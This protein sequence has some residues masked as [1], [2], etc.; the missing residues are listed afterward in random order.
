MS[1]DHIRCFSFIRHNACMF[2]ISSKD[3]KV[4]VRFYKPFFFFL[5][6]S[7]MQFSGFFLLLKVCLNFLTLL[8]ISYDYETVFLL[9][10]ISFYLL[11][12]MNTMFTFEKYKC[13]V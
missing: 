8:K 13:F 3:V 1:N 10:F 5:F 12:I 6:K 9:I 7:K 11:L 2:Y 4:E